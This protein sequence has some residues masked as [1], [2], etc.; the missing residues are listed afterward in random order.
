LGNLIDA[1]V[2]TDLQATYA[3]LDPGQLRS[4]VFSAT[5]EVLAGLNNQR[6]LVVVF[7][8]LHWA[9][10]ATIEFVTNLL[11][12]TET[13]PLAVILVYRPRRNE[14]SWGVHEAAVRNHPHRYEA[15]ELNALDDA[16]SR[17]LVS[18]LLDIDGLPDP[19]RDKILDKSEGNPF[20]M[21][22]VLRAM[23]DKGMVVRSDGRWVADAD[24]ADMVVPDTLSAV[25]TT[26]LDSLA[27]HP[28]RTAQAAS[29]IGREFRY[30][31][32][33]A[34][35]TDLSQVDEAL[36]DLQRRDIVREVARSPRRVF[37]FKHALVQATVYETVLRKN[38]TE[39]HAALAAHLERLHPER[40][41]DI[42]DH[43]L[44]A[45]NPQA[46][47]PHVIR[48]GER[49]LHTYTL[50]EAVARF[51]QAL[52]I[53]GD[54]ANPV[55][56]RRVLERLGQAKE[57]QF[58]FAG[59]AEV[60]ERLRDEGLR[61]QDPAMAI[62]GK[63]KNAL[64]M[65]TAFQNRD[66]ALSTL[67]E[68]ESDAR[69]AGDDA[70][71]AE[72][73]MF[74]C[75]LKT[76]SGEFD[77]V[78]YYM[79]ELARLGE[80]LEDP[81][82]LT[83]GMVHLAN[84]YVYTNRADDAVEQGQKAL[85]KAEEFGD[86]KHQAELLTFALP[87]G[88]FQRGETDLALS[89]VERGME[90]ALRI[91]DRASE[92]MGTILLGKIATL[93]GHFEEALAMFRRTD[94]AATA[95]GAPYF[96]SIGKCLIGTCYFTIGG[97]LVETALEFHR[98]ALQMTDAPMGDAMGAWIWSEIGACSLAAGNTDL[99]EELFT[100]ALERPTAAM[101]IMQPAALKGLCDVALVR[102][103]LDEA[104]RY[105]E[106]LAGYVQEHEMH[107]YDIVVLQA[108]AMVATAERNLPVALAALDRCRDDS[109]D[110]GFRR[111]QLWVEAARH[112]TMSDLGDQ[113]GAAQAL[114]EVHR[115]A[116]QISAA[117]QDAGLRTA[118]QAS[119]DQLLANP[120][121]L[122]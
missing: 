48:A 15:V 59:A 33:A 39:M 4:A 61:R 92:A 91:G 113:A 77:D 43:H 103:D 62:S 10:S 13:Q 44:A 32:L 71:L 27:T 45:R 116:D 105:L 104:R 101:F 21:E 112:R 31:E 98:E 19:V 55:E 57:F 76:V 47:L 78:A 69:G 102:G 70:G 30:D 100:R 85:A 18:A 75:M 51:E 2:P 34:V 35:L 117:T 66:L 93:R 52:E 97:P 89:C 50:P 80:G 88:H 17:T 3:F 9:D 118:F 82:T 94:A 14:P 56:L 28:R 40:V 121:L 37:R 7:E 64:V 22:E 90:I 84:T 79:G 16:E 106:Q 20:F 65:G 95:T 46:A 114:T 68:A 99:A 108:Q 74:Q 38:R 5:I 54:E 63:N 41:E 24:A 120:A 25:I 87:F 67:S 58:D 1:S 11:N 83:F 73:C 42:A 107:H 36:V 29:V 111:L 23:I 26:R 12:C 96:A 8:D 110:A 6:P 53:L 115:I 49:A 109:R 122:P 60:Y 119:V 81:Y 72:A 86:L